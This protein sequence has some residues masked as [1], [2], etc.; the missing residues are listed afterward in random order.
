MIANV[1][2]TSIIVA[3]A[4]FVSIVNKP[5]RKKAKIK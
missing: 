4:I 5:M 1:K 2:E 3:Y